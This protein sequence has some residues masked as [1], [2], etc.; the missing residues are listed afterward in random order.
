M[1][2]RRLSNRV[3]PRLLSDPDRHV[4]DRDLQAIMRRIKIGALEAAFSGS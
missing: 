4:A 1:L 3:L 2:Q